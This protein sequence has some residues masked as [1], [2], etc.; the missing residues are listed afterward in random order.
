MSYS[1]KEIVENEGFLNIARAIRRATVNAQYRKASGSQVFEIHY[2]L[3]QEWKR[4]V[5]YREQFVMALSEFVQEYNAENARHAEQIAK[6]PERGK[7][8][9]ESISIND[10]NEV[11]SLTEKFGSELVG[12]LLLAY[13]YAKEENKGKEDVQ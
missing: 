9:R 11:I 6:N 1:L 7:E 5:K 3:A 8:R 13:G 10:L 4:K 12:M 2:G